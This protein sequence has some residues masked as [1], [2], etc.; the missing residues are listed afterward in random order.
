MDVLSVVP[1]SRKTTHYL[2][3]DNQLVGY[4]KKVLKFAQNCKTQNKSS[5]IQAASVHNKKKYPSV[6]TNALLSNKHSS[7]QKHPAKF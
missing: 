5:S 3:I 4:Q 2:I 1:V 6:L 7:L